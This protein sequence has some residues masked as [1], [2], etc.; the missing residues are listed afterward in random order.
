MEK[1]LLCVQTTVN[2]LKCALRCSS[3]GEL[4]FQLFSENI[5]MHSKSNFLHALLSLI[6]ILTTRT[7]ICQNIDNFSLTSFRQGPAA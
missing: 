5:K 4:K 1:T 6:E 7:R 2:L 3:G